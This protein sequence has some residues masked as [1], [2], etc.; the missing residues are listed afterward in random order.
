M[1]MVM[2][3]KDT[4]PMMMIQEEDE[5]WG[6]DNAYSEP[7]GE[8]LAQRGR[9]KDNDSPSFSFASPSLSTTDL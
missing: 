7:L 3:D 1:D 8:A 5:E 4:M 6:A 2:S 9:K